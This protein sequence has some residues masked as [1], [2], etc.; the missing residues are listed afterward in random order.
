MDNQIFNGERLK[1]ALQFREK[2]MTM[3]AEETGIRKQ[4]LS[5]YANGGNVPPYEN[6]KKIADS[7]NFPVD[8]FMTKDL[9]TTITGNIYF[10]SQASATKKSR[11]A[12]KIKLEYVAKM[13]EVLLD[14]INFPE[15]NLPE[16]IDIN[17]PEDSFE[18]DSET[19]LIEIEK[20]A[21]QVRA[22][23]KLGD[24]PIENLQYVLESN[25]II[26]TGF[27]DVNSAIDAFSQQIKV[28]KKTVYI[29]A[30][31][32]GMKPIERLRFDMA[33][34]LGHILMH[35][36]EADN[37]CITR[38]EFNAREKQAN[39]FASAFLLPKDSFVRTV[40]A[41]PTNIDYYKFLKK[42]WKVS[43]QAMMYQARQLN[44]ISANQFQ[45]MM[46]IVSKNGWRTKEPGD[47]PGQI[48][49]TIFQG[50]IDLLF[51]G[52]YMTV[53]ELLRDFASYGI[54]LSQKDL[55]NFM[56]LRKG[57]LKQKEKIIPFMS[58]KKD[59]Q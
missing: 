41:Y 30:L 58:V 21:A 51:D 3:L 59:N 12:Q 19:V 22:Y 2:T 25:G 40:A 56:C 33:H 42:K 9:C 43:M 34:E 5:L 7:L 23:W 32:T 36:W 57:T 28:N 17:L 16:D 47:V 20:L 31:A 29:V 55:E 13:Y 49:E 1:E 45:Y 35:S 10:R 8:F 50:A 6:V 26:V 38:D 39:M 15:V 11:N 37:D 52:G 53:D 48:G 14:Y 24:G 46:R 54:I 44:V 27:R 18:A 4:S